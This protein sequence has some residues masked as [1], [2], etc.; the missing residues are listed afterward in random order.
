MVMFEQLPI[1][2]LNKEI[3]VGNVIVYPGRRGSSLWIN[4]AKV[5]ELK[6]Y[7]DYRGNRLLKLVVDRYDNPR[8]RKTSH[9]TVVECLGRVV[10]LEGN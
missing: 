4:V 1:D 10:V 9:R 7:T 8:E 2:K 5:V 3:K 6:Y